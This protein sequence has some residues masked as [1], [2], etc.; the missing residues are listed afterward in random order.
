MD[1][2]IV[3]IEKIPEEVRIDSHLGD[4]LGQKVMPAPRQTCPG[5]LGYFHP[6]H[7]YS[8]LS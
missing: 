7:N 5:A 6:S 1:Q 4:R 3:C 2:L 8:L